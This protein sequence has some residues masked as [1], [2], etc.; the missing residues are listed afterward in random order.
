MHGTVRNPED[1]K[2][3]AH[4][5]ELKNAS[6]HLKLFKGELD[7]EGAFDEP[8]KGNLPIHLFSR[9]KIS[10]ES[11]IFKGAY[12]VI[13]VASPYF[14]VAN[15][16]EKEIIQPAIA[17][18]K[19][20]TKSIDKNE[21]VKVTILTSSGL[22][23]FMSPK[24]PGHVFSEEDWSDVEMMKKIG[25][26]YGISK[27]LAE[28]VFWEWA[29]T[30]KDKV[31]SVSV[32]PSLVSGP[33]L[34]ADPNTS[35]NNFLSMLDGSKQKVPNSPIALV[36]VRDAALAHVLALEKQVEGRIFAVA[37]GT[38]F[39]DVANFFRKEFPERLALIPNEPDLKEGEQLKQP[40]L[41]NNAKAISL[42]IEFI[43]IE[44]SLREMVE[45]VIQKGFLK[46][47]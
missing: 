25:Q 47:I 14:Y 42:G 6:T 18:V 5:F 19:N 3:N 20:I 39:L 17:G 15:D 21:T 38:T 32:A 23:M 4:L 2:K 29:E 13:H 30:K 11:K 24:P 10:C 28:K 31:R 1:K 8:V 27:T 40:M 34:Q 46:K 37:K 45:Q 35:N 9:V 36:D 22:A 33:P 7:T 16:P 26:N 43:D 41:V 12:G 44:Q